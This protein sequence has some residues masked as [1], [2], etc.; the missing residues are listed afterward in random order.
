MAE[1]KIYDTTLRDGAQAEGIAFSVEDKLMIAQELDRVG[2]HYIEGGWPNPTNPKDLSFFIRAKELSL[3]NSVI[4]AFGSTRRAANAPEKDGTLNTLLSAETEAVAIFGKSWDLHVTDVLRT[5]LDENLKIIEDSIAYMKARGKEIIYDAEHYFDGYKNNPEYALK[6][7]K[8]AESGGADIIVLCDTNGGCL[9][10]EFQGVVEETK[11][12]I[13]IPFGIHVHNDS[14]VAV[15]NSVIA[16]ELGAIQVQGT[17]NGFGERCGNANLCTVIPNLKLKLGIDCIS[18]DNIKRISRVS[19]FVSEIANVA[20]DHRQPYVGESAFAHKGGAHVDGVIKVTRSF[21]HINPDL[22]GNERRFLLSDQAGTSVIVDKISQIK[23]GLNKRD[24]VVRELLEK[25][26]NMENQGYSFEAAG[27]S[28]EL[29]ARKFLKMYEDPFELESFRTIVEKRGDGGRVFSEATVRIVVDGEE[30]Y[31]AA[32]G[33]GPVNALDS[34]LRKALEVTYPELKEVR[35]EDYKVRVLSSSAGTASKVRV[36]IES[37][38]GKE[39]WGT[40]GVSENIIEASWIALAD[41]LSY[42]ILKTKGE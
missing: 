19:R 42:K 2:I 6:T 4:V 31:M 21:E 8:A 7:L 32:E 37:S 17:I 36:L 40:V 20:H 28:F 15:A 23:T 27:G 18:D 22:V 9:P 16:V 34:A 10:S 3:E 11:R 30:K 41:S 38:D 29:L 14:G 39:I 26:K 33:D 12:H 5:T 1:V 24:P 25:L 13:S 35:L